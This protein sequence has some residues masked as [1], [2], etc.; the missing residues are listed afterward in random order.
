YNGDDVTMCNSD[1][2]RVVATIPVGHNP[3]DIVWSP[4]G[5]FMFVVNNGSN[6]VSVI[7]AW[8]AKVID[9]IPAGSGPTSIAVGPDDRAYVTNQ[10]SNNLSVLQFATT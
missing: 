3:Q 8:S 6:N 7:D 1:T 10:N 9:T 5:Q 2:L 4:D